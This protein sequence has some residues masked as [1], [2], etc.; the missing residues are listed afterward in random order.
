MNKLKNGFTIVEVLIALFVGMIVMAAIYGMI[1]L[2]QGSSAGVSR[3]VLT[4]QDARAVLNLMSMEISMA[5][6][7]PNLTL[8][9]WSDANKV[10]CTCFSFSDTTTQAS[11]GIQLAS[12]TQ[13]GVAMDLGSNVTLCP[14]PTTAPCI[15]DVANE[16]IVYTYNSGNSTITRSTN[17]GGNEVILG[18]TAAGSSTMVRNNDLGVSLF[19]YFDKFGTEI[20]TL[21][22]TTIPNIIGVR[23]NIVADDPI[24]D[25]TKG[26]SKVSKRIYSTNVLVRNHA[27]AY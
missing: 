18:G 9:T 13:I 14:S 10:G 17:C 22:D 1:N 6:Y 11:R 4:Q 2:G 19:Q 26:V 12:P 15:G 25:T 23:I 7:N 3:R 16:Y 21:N 8:N 5:S 24:S 20:T 27:M